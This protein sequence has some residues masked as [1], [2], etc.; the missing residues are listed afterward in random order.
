MLECRQVAFRVQCGH[1]AG[2]GGS[3]GLA[4]DGI[5]DIARRKH[6]RHTGRRGIPTAACIDHDLAV[7]HLQLAVEHLRV[8]LVT[9]GNKDTL[10]GQVFRLMFGDVTQTH[11]GY[12]ES[13]PVRVQ[14]SQ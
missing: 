14:S 9:D 2:A 5:G 10:Y 11:S 12:A 7:I 3:D 13:F 4:V 6:P 8:W 1:G